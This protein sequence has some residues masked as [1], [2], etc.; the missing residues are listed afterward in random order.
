MEH[1]KWKKAYS[2][3]FRFLATVIVAMVAITVFIGGISIYEVD[4]YVQE[5]AEDF[6][7]VTCDNEAAQINGS[8]NNMEK[9]V[10][11]MESYLMDFFTDKD[12]LLDRDLQKRVIQSADQMF[13]DVAKHTSAKG[14]V[15]YYFRFDPAISDNTSGLFYSKTEG[16]DEFLSLPPTDI[17]LYERDDT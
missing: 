15:A 10:K 11:I 8:L 17:S 16:G 5:Q 9:S 3:R 2:L 6:V 13:V 12:D 1:K 4:Q 7:S 14:A